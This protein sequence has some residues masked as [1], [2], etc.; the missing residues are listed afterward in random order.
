MERSIS[1]GDQNKKAYL[2][3]T[4]QGSRIEGLYLEVEQNN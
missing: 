2:F 4:A 1:I 3:H